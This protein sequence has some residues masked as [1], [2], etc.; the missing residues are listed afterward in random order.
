MLV[1]SL[2][3]GLIGGAKASTLFSD[4]AVLQ[5]G[6]PIPIF[7]TGDPGTIV[8]VTIDAVKQEGTVSAD[9]TW[10]VTFPRMQAGGPHTISL[11]GSVVA[12]DVLVGE[13]WI[14]SGQSNM[15]WT[16]NSATD[17][18]DATANPNPQIRQFYVPHLSTETPRP[19]PTGT[20]TMADATNVGNFSAVG[21]WFARELNKTLGVPV[22]I[23]HSSWGGTPAE[24]WTRRTT[25]KG[26]KDLSILAERYETNLPNFTKATEEYQA[27]LDEFMKAR[28]DVPRQP[29]EVVSLDVSDWKQIESPKPIEVIDGQDEDGTAWYRLTF[30]L[31]AGV[32]PADATLELGAIDDHDTTFLNGR[33]VGHT[34][35]ETPNSWT[36]PRVYSVS[37]SDLKTTGNVLAVRIVDGSGGGG[38]IGPLDAIL[39]RMG[40]NVV[41]LANG[42]WRFKGERIV[43]GTMPEAPF[44]PGHPWVPGGLWNGM[45][46]PLAPYGI[47]GAIWYQGESNADRA[48][49]Y[50][51][52]FPTMIK[53]WREAWGQGDFPFLF[54]Q[55]ANFMSTPKEPTESQWAELREAQAMT[56][57]L[58][59]TGMA[60]AIDI[61]EAGD[62][63]PKNKHEVGR[64]LGLTALRDVYGKKIVANGPRFTSFSRKAGELV[65]K[66]SDSVDLKTTDSKAPTSFQIAGADRKWHWA[67]AKIDGATVVLSSPSVPAPVAARYAWS[68]N[69]SV[70]LTNGDGL[71]AEP[72]RTDDWPG[73]TVDK[74]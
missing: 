7:G 24:S 62:I 42:D 65:I 51:K 55:L 58:A 15:E 4:G 36:H 33:E 60:T 32:T 56:L 13:V 28:A 57:R 2:A 12:R 8:E 71:P 38:M 45:M 1:L 68:D 16:A 70:N 53:D 52:L 14:A 29:W 39:L 31:P 61:G 73:L 23:V 3:L 25:L 44:G 41:P 34:G 35:I 20:W 18:A 47:R 10:K 46:A 69:P 17:F 67:T 30:D 21:Y 43:T 6:R 22:G 9:G 50:R 37:A 5:R 74:K 19:D 49:Q 54:V 11:N 40:G 48:F 72:F 27:K 63:H 66:F 59:R 64:R 26:D